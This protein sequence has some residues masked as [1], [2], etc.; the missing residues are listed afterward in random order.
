MIFK[1]LMVKFG[2]EKRDWK[3][4]L[5]RKLIFKIVFIRGRVDINLK[6]VSDGKR[7]VYC[8]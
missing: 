1:D 8:L 7:R 6:G 3:M 5:L 2:I 4:K